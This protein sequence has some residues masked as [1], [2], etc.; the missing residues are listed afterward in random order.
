MPICTGLHGAELHAYTHV[1]APPTR[2]VIKNYHVGS[3]S[4]GGAVMPSAAVRASSVPV[5]SKAILQ[6]LPLKVGAVLCPCSLVGWLHA[7]SKWSWC[8]AHWGCLAARWQQGHAGKLYWSL[9]NPEEPPLAFGASVTLKGLIGAYIASTSPTL[10]CLQVYKRLEDIVNNCSYMEWKHFD[11]GVIKVR[12][13][14]DPWAGNVREHWAAHRL[15]SQGG[16]VGPAAWRGLGLGTCTSIGAR[17]ALGARGGGG[18]AL[19]CGGGGPSSH[20]PTPYLRPQVMGQLSDIGEE[21]VFEE[22]AL[23]ENTDLSS[24]E[25][26]PVGGG[27]EGA[28]LPA[29][30][31]TGSP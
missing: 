12:L 14:R 9:S 30:P 8:A 24:V 28:G 16:R 31:M 18:G 1:Y 29:L 11:A 21:D 15:A 20:Q 10:V 17:T 22:L 2:A 13:L 23:L 3:G 6:K 26:M 7:Q 25:Y 27:R 5:S 19:W 4:E